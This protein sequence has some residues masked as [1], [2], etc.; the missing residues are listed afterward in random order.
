MIDDF[1]ESYKKNKEVYLKVKVKP[2]ATK[3]EIVDILEDDTIKINIS[4]VPEKG[5]AN[6]ELVGFLKDKFRADNVKI[7]SGKGERIKLV[8][9]F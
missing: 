8:K 7:I 5:K 9:I 3:N 1:L 6:K 2:R 4:A